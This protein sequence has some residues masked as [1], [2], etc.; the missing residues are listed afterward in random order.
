MRNFLCSLAA[1]SVISWA[2]L[3]SA[4]FLPIAGSGYDQNV[5]VGVGETFTSAPITATMDGGITKS[6]N[7]WYELGQNTAAKT[8]G[9][10]MGTTFTVSSSATGLHT[11][12]LQGVDTNNA[13]CVGSSGTGGGGLGLTGTFTLTTPAEYPAISFLASSGNG[14]ANNNIDVTFHYA[15]STTFSS[16]FSAGDWFGNTPVAYDAN[17][18]IASSGY[19][20]VSSGNP[21]LYYYDVTGLPTSSDLQSISFTFAGTG[22]NTHTAIMGISGGTAVVPEP[23]VLV[24]LGAGLLFGLVVF[25]RKRKPV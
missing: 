3:A 21:N 20:N 23:S 11:F 25:W 19:A 2:G 6:G 8:T 18:R 12:Q 9:L 10:P 15:G 14:S 17:G 4:Q 22:S 1:L 16:T 5:V 13:I 24:L 7:T